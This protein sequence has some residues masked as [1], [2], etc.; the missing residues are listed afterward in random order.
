MPGR[1]MSHPTQSVKVLIFPVYR[2]YWLYHAWREEARDAA[3]AVP[4]ALQW[5]NGR[6]LEERVQAFTSSLSQKVCVLPAAC[7][8]LL[9]QLVPLSKKVVHSACSCCCCAG[10]VLPVVVKCPS[11]L[12]R[13]C[14]H[15]GP[16]RELACHAVFVP[17]CYPCAFPMHVCLV[18]TNITEASLLKRAHE[19]V[20]STGCVAQVHTKLLAQWR[21]LQDAKQGTFKHW[22]YRCCPCALPS[23]PCGAP[24]AAVHHAKHCYFLTISVARHHAGL[25]VCA[26]RSHVCN[27]GWEHCC[28]HAP[29]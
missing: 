23:L 10:R 1:C 27:T 8:A 13:A 5:N 14:G 19:P 9:R 3:A 6:N 4:P 21:N 11:S 29:A 18:S 24:C 7:A 16:V 28:R 22:L 2:N 15:N 17:C 25:S 20:P 26:C 12:R